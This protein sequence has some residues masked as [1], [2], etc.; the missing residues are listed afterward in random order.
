VIPQTS[1]NPH[2]AK[3]AIKTAKPFQAR[4][5]N[6]ERGAISIVGLGYVGLATAVCLASRGFDVTGIDIDTGKVAALE[7]G[8]STI[9]EE[10]LESLLR[11]SLRRKTLHLRS[12]YEG[13]RR[14]K[15]I[16]I[17]VGTPSR[18]DG[19]VDLGFVEGASKKIGA[20][21]GLATGYRLVVVKSTV[22]PGTTEGLVRQ[23]L[24][25]ESKKKVGPDFGLASN[26]EF[27]REGSAIRETF[28]PDAIV[29]GGHDRRST[30]T[31]LR[32][33]DAF[34]GR[35]ESMILTTPPNAEMMKYAINAGRATQ[36][37]FVNT[38]AN[39]CTRI[40]GCDY[41]E[42]RKGLSTVAR[43]DERY[44]GAGLGFGGS[45]VPPYTHVATE[46]GFRRISSIRVGD[47]VFS[48]DGRL[49]RVSRTFTRDYD[50]MLYLFRSQ[51][52][53]STPL[54]VTPEHP[55]LSC[56]RNTG[57]R[58]RFYETRIAGRG[59]VQKMNNLFLIEPP[60]FADPS[61]LSQGDF[62]ILPAIREESTGTP[63]LDI[64]S[65][66]RDHTIAVCPDLMYLFGLWL[67]EG[68]LDT[69]RGEVLFSFHAREGHFLK[70]IDEITWLYFG[71]K[72]SI[73]K[74]LSKGNSLAVRVKSKA[75]ADFLE[76]T[77]GRGAENKHI[78]WE[79]L[80]LPSSMLVPLVRGMWYGDGSNRNTEPYGRFTYATV[81]ASLADFMELALLKLKVPYRRLTSRE[82][83]D[84]NGV[85][86]RVS[87]SFLGVDNSVMN[88]LLPRL[89]VGLVSQQQRTSWFEGDSYLFP[90]KEVQVV[91][92]KG[93]VHNL[94]V[95]D[96][97]SY[98][99]RGATLHN[100]LP[101]DSRALAFALKSSGVEHELVSNA[102]RV[103][104][105]QV[106]EAI[107]LAE[108]LCGSL[109]GK[110]VALLGLA[111]KPET[112]DI[113]EAV[114][115]ALAKSLVQ[116]GAEVTAYD[117]AAMEGARAALGRQV[118][119]AKTARDALRG[120]ECAFLATAWD[121][122]NRLR[123]SDFKALM[124]SPAVV[125][126]RRLY[127]PKEFARAGVRFAAIGTGPHGD[128]SPT[129]RPPKKRR[130]WHYIVK[131]GKVHQDVPVEAE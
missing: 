53:S 101:K 28:H 127:D 12:D 111:F 122:F 57:G 26:P 19:R 60:Q 8:V 76:R 100:C 3:Q 77:F 33:Y 41:D 91:K 70:E 113:R 22:T 13:L 96:S 92:Y 117:P 82:R 9:H 85:H 34:H 97:N 79:W 118:T 125:D 131:D 123:A 23:V 102:L 129:L 11:R 67:A 56:Q 4:M 6:P 62:M 55:I 31:L 24:E 83:T 93:R 37:S 75:L 80:K 16:F 120:S 95:E 51:G 72:A 84:R 128:G 38:V 89:E 110:R 15:I 21:L 46:S 68:A 43:M 107:R 99:V 126:G 32:M 52:F 103:N 39:Y 63:D 130:E 78:P 112:D 45:C 98:V 35:R 119:F 69:K 29:I 1:L 87:Y 27:L 71:V 30:N 42:V 5:S 108:K 116:K 40:P 2:F 61:L 90:I 124:A 65:A 105:G 36:V 66:R 106:G 49:H 44:L 20:Q 88:K 25:R 86:H 14:S 47:L 115:I 74:S 114:P 64:T 73:K 59:L 109:E 121:A 17:T 10:G 81:S 54:A 18:E 7:K 48:H 50:G 94:E 58:S 104:S